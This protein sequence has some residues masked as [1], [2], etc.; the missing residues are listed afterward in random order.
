MNTFG[1]KNP[2]TG[3]HWAGCTQKLYFLCPLGGARTCM[4]SSGTKNACIGK[5][6]KQTRSSL[7][8]GMAQQL[9]WQ[10]RLHT[11]AAAP[12]SGGLMALAAA[13]SAVSCTAITLLRRLLSHAPG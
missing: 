1:P 9:H 3:E 2:F 11:S 8:S 13:L 10:A 12:R 5:R 4:N 6:C 7:S